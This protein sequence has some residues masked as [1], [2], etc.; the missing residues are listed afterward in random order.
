MIS[1]KDV[2]SLFRYLS[3]LYEQIPLMPADRISH[4]IKQSYTLSQTEDGLPISY[5]NIMSARLENGICGTK[6][7]HVDEGKGQ[8]SSVISFVD[9][10]GEVRSV[11][12]DF[13][14]PLR[15]GLMVAHALQN[16]YG[17]HRNSEIRIGLIGTGKINRMTAYVLRALWGINNFVAR[18]SPLNPYKNAHQLRE[19]DSFSV[20]V[21]ATEDL[22][23]L[24]T[25]YAVISAT[26]TLSPAHAIP[27]SLFAGGESSPSLFIAQDSGYIFGPSFREQLPSYADYPDQLQAHF[28]E[29]FPYDSEQVV[30]H[31]LNR[32]IKHNRA[33]V[34]L[35]GM[36]FADVAVAHYLFEKGLL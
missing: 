11:S 5:V 33:A 26:N 18:G 2:G 31:P 28:A 17:I 27:F 20:E 3:D 36:A 6:L 1:D 23:L 32:G 8:S 25:C 16:Y 24:N 13:I 4:P 15:C 9:G 19:N 30:F 29:E 34:Y 22:A 7:I 10:T 21:D 35:Y 12:G 14:T